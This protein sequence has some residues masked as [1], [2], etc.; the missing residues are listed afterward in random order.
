MAADNDFTL[1][2]DYL[3]QLEDA[4]SL[5]NNL[6]DE[7]MRM[8]NISES[9]KQK[10]KDIVS[11][12]K[13]QADISDQITQLVQA[14]DEF[15]ENEV[16]AGRIISKNALDKL[17]AEI[18]LLKLKEK[19][20]NLE[21]EIKE[22]FEGTADSLLET[23]GLSK[24][25]FKN[26]VSFGLGMLVAKKGAEMLTTAFDSTVL[27]AKELY[28]HLGTTA[29]ESARIGMEVGKASFSMVGF[30]HGSEAVA[31]SAKEMAS[32]FNSTAMIS[33]ETLQ[34]VTELNGMMEDGAGAVRMN[35]IMEST[36]G[37][38]LHLTHSIKDIANKSG[39]AAS[40][41]FKE[42]D[43]QAGKLLGK[44]EKE[45]EIIAKQTAAMVK[46]GLTKEN[47]VT[48]SDSVLDIENSIAAQNKARLFGVE[49]NTQAIRDAAVAYQYGGGSAE[50][51]AKAI[52]EQV[53]SAE[54]FGKMAPGIQKIYADQIG[55]TTDQITDMLLKQEELTKNTEK[56]G[57]DGAKAV[58]AIG[59]AFDATK[60]FASSAIP[61]LASTSMLMSNLGMNTQSF[62][63][64]IGGAFSKLKNLNPFKAM[65]TPDFNMGPTASKP[66]VEMPKGNDS[67]GMSSMTDAIEKI[68]PQQLLAGGAALVLVAAAVFVFAKAV[69]EFMNV[70]WEAVAMAV[71][72]MLALVGALALVGL[73]ASGPQAMFLLAGAAAMLVIAA[74]IYVLGKAIQEMATGFKMMGDI[75]TQLTGLVNIA[76][77]LLEL[78][79]IFGLLGL[80]LV[81][82]A[83]GLAAVSAFL[84]TLLILGAV[85][86]SITSALGIGG[87]SSETISSDTKKSDPLLEE[88]KGLRADIKAQ[89]INVVLNNKIVGE[90]NRASRASNS[91]VNK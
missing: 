45:L 34:N 22:L 67:K 20:L 83:V 4:R 80:S 52:S 70:S 82:L 19:Q 38:A 46:L 8:N 90:I 33:S 7:F 88:I 63:K 36:G 15:I 43:A 47:L 18:K 17:D 40:A 76:P 9:T 2:R 51:F 69:Q 85:L 24:E 1:G 16:A 21:K 30:M 81:A 66:N 42:M 86:P 56:Y 25:M 59:T 37:H 13:G 27:L 91:Y 6:A 29:G 10:M 31:T 79:G 35:A 62:G 49:M 78:A 44:S 77:G 26:G 71:V 5:S 11:S 72:S 28:H 3:R 64:S 12:L 61:L 50:D 14:R 57:E 75:T 54:E 73:I 32:Y 58:A 84:P 74:A 60:S 39:V 48:V 53:G 65:P 55:M 89:P 41:V 68:K 23:V 87:G